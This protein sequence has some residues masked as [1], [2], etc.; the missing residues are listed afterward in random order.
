MQDGPSTRPQ[1]SHWCFTEYDAECEDLRQRLERINLRFW[2]FQQE[3][4]PSTGRLHFQGYLEYRR[5]VRMA[6]VKRDMASPG[7]HLEP[8][9]GSR[10]EARNYCEKDESRI[11]G[12]WS[13][14]T[15]EPDVPGRRSDLSRAK[16]LL[17]AGCGDVDLADECF[18]VWVKYRNS[19]SA[20]RELKRA[21]PEHRDLRVHILWGPTGTGKTHRATEHKP[22]YWILTRPATKNM[23]LWFDGYQGQDCVVIDE[24]YGWIPFDFLLRFLDK[25]RLQLSIRGGYVWAN[26]TTVF[27]TSNM[28]P[29]Q[30]YPGVPPERRAALDRRFTT[31][32]E[33]TD[34]EMVC[35]FD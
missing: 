19:F 14:G 34:K 11:A 31:V 2:I 30:W 28:D 4:C 8:R 35:D 7:V 13:G 3:R 6:T 26:F 25:Y 5:S 29:A 9:K 24:F 32:T 27:I 16:E 21:R 17:D 10:T 18:D 15:W 20:Y 12:P 22:D 1:V 23:P 33:V